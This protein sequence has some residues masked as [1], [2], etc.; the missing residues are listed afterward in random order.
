MSADSG[1]WFE[2]RERDSAPSEGD[3][4]R[5]LRPRRGGEARLNLSEILGRSLS[6]SERS[7]LERVLAD[8]LAEMPDEHREVVEL[9]IWRNEPVSVEEVAETQGVSVDTVVERLTFVTRRLGAV[10][11]RTLGE[12][13]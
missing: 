6:E 3:A 7:R 11:R 13:E 5:E 12:M 10:V 8:T 4:A 1:G 2:E 9:V